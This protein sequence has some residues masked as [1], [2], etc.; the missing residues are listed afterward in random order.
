VSNRRVIQEYY[1][2]IN[3][4]VDL[5]SKLSNSY[6]LLVAGAGEL[7]V[8]ALANKKDVRKAIKRANELGRVIDDLI[9]TLDIADTGYLNYVELKNQ[10][11]S[12]RVQVQALEV[13]INEAVKYKE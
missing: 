11:I 3:G 4:I 12:A 8:I 10:I 5:L 13:E 7:N 6:R 2:D 1:N 9:R